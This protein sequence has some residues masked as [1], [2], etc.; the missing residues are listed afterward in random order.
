M[1]VNIPRFQTTAQLVTEQYYPTVT[2]HIWWDTVARNIEGQFDDINGALTD[3]QQLQTDLSNT[4]ADLQQAVIDIQT[5][6]AAAEAAQTTA[7]VVTRDDAITAS[8]TAPGTT[9]S[10]SDAGTDATITIA[11]HTRVYGDI[12]NVAVTGGNVNGLNYSTTYYIYYD[13]INRNGGSVSYHATTNSNTALPTKAAGRH[14]VGKVVTPASG[15]T[16]TSGGTSSPSGGGGI[17]RNEINS[18]L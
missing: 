16:A 10:A 6:Q 3:I 8:Y 13:D 17:D 9:L 12:S 4:V 2:F 15:G 5:A 1:S 11:D 18:T 7:D 14:Y